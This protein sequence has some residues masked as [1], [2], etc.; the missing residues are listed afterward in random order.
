[1]NSD[2]WTTKQTFSLWASRSRQLGCLLLIKN[3]LNTNSRFLILLTN[4]HALYF[5]FPPTWRFLWCK[6]SLIIQSSQS[7]KT[8]KN[9]IHKLNWIG[10]RGMSQHNFLHFFIFL[11]VTFCS[12]S[13][14]VCGSSSFELHSVKYFRKVKTHFSL[15]SG[16]SKHLAIWNA[17][18]AP[19]SW[20]NLRYL[21]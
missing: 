1:M 9:N 8:S 3:L 17:N 16:S 14:S 20:F 5:P 2:C 4:A 19:H 12:I 13:Y 15:F 6:H 11:R 21:D 10:P 7:E 18:L